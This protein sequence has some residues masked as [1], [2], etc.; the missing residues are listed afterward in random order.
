MY[1]P[2]AAP[3][4]V[5][6]STYPPVVCGI[7]TYMSYLIRAM[8]PGRASVVAFDPEHYGGSVVSGYAGDSP[9][10][11]SSVLR[12]PHSDESALAA[13]VVSATPGPLEQTV[14]WF[15]HAPDIWPQ[16][17]ELLHDLADFPVL[18]VASLHVVHF[19]SSETGSG[20]RRPELQMLQEILPMLDRVT[21]FSPSAREAVCAAFPKHAH[22]VAVIQHGFHTPRLLNRGTARRL[23]RDYVASVPHA[24]QPRGSASRLMEALDDPACVVVGTLGFLQWGKGYEAVFELRDRMQP[25]LPG[26]HVVA[27]VMGSL[28]EPDD[29]RNQRLLARL[30]EE[31]DGHDR[32]LVIAIPADP[33]FQ[34][35]L[36]ALDVNLYWP[37]ASTQSGRVAHAVGV[38]ATVIGRDI[39]GVGETLHD[40]GAPVCTT[41]DDLDCSALQLVEDSALTASMRT[42][43]RRY[44][45]D[46]SWT[47]QARR[48]LML[49]DRLVAQNARTIV[50]TLN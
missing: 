9:P 30:S 13:A 48:H 10:P 49:A 20:L 15:Q 47:E 36:R 12:R 38:G 22:K 18:K 2:S 14:L 16:F 32:F 27:L 44:A 37:D 1:G 34:A 41:L 31:A 3:H 46:H 28:R 50:P 21:V 6:A 24:V 11:A 5:F 42:R 4:V 25:S 33:E 45:R 17:G 8:T 43:A 26:R 29:P 7:G 39:E 23:L 19:E 40:V 35:G